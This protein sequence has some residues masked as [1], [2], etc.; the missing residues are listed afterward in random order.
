[1]EIVDLIINTYEVGEDRYC[2]FYYPEANHL[3]CDY[4][5]GN[6]LTDCST[7]P[8]GIIDVFICTQV[9]NVIYD[10]KK[11]IKGAYHTL[12]SGGIMFATVMG[13]ISQVSRSDMRNYGDYWRFTDLSIRMLVE[14]VFGKGNV[15]VTAFG[16][17]MATTAYIQGMC[18]EDLPYPELLDDIDNEFALD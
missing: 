12:K 2:K 16:N 6:D 4:S 18:V 17:A 13:N 10:V 7:L 14:E 15:T 9:F 5:K 8:D 1:M 11:A 3:V